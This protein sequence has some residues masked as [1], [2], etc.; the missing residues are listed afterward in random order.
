MKRYL[1]IYTTFLKLNYT[2][3]AL[4]RVDFL[5]GLVSSILWAVFSIIAIYALT[6]RSSTIFG[7]SR[8]ELFVLIGVFNILIG[9]IFRTVFARNFDRFGQIVQRGELDGILLKPF[10][11]Q[12][13]LSFQYISLYGIVRIILAIIFTAFLLYQ[14]HVTV[15]FFDVIIFIMLAGF[16]LLTMYSIWFIVLTLTIWHPDLFNLIETLYAVDSVTRYPPQ[17]INQFKILLF[18]LLFPFT[19]IVSIPTKALL[20]KLTSF[21][22]IILMGMSLILFYFSR[23]FWRFA[24]RSYTSASG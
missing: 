10:D 13:S 3:F 12:F 19:L 6:A 2:R 9:G 15:T 23:I 8:G 7:W 20:H 11:S 21:D 4:Y 5:N 18:Y 22:V 24:L 1:T 17:I 14:I 16:G